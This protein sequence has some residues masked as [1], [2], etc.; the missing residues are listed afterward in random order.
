M[1][2][3]VEEFWLDPYHLVETSSCSSSTLGHLLV[4]QQLLLEQQL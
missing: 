2:S 3:L 4:A 1:G